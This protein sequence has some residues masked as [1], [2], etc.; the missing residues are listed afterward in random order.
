MTQEHIEPQ[1]T[2]DETKVDE[3]SRPQAIVSGELL[4]VATAVRDA[5]DAWVSRMA[6]AGG[7]GRSATIVARMATARAVA[8]LRGVQAPESEDASA[9]TVAEYLRRARS[10]LS[11]AAHDIERNSYSL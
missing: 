3:Q 8:D 4:E 11:N 2:N 7:T 5:L 6:G 9:S 1:A 10:T